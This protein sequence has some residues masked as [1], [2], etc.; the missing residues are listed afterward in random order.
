MGEEGAGLCRNLSIERSET[1]H[2]ELIEAMWLTWVMNIVSDENS[3]CGGLSWPSSPV[4]VQKTECSLTLSISEYFGSCVPR[5]KKGYKIIH[6][7][8]LT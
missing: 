1:R 3:T 8:L 4:V 6:A 2:R 5:F 7:L